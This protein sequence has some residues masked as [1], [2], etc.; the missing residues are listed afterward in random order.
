M[1]A[2]TL[3]RK[4]TAKS[5]KRLY[6][7]FHRAGAVIFGV[8][9]IVAATNI[10]ICAEETPTLDPQRPNVF[11]MPAY[12]ARQTR[13]T[14][15]VLLLV[16]KKQYAEAEK[17]LRSLIRQYPH[18]PT[19][20]Y[21]LGAVLARQNKTEEAF[22][23]LATAIDRGFANKKVMK[24][25]ADLDSLRHLPRFQK[26]IKKQE[27]VSARKRQQASAQFEL[28]VVQAARARVTA[29]NTLWVPRNNILVSAF[30]FSPKPESNHVYGGD[31]PVARRLNLW[32]G[33][34][35]AAG[36]HGD[37]YDNRDG[38]HSSI[39][40]AQLPQLAHIEYSG[41]ARQA[42]THYGF[43]SHFL[44]S[45]ITFGNSS[46]ALTGG[47]FWRSQA[48][49]ALTTPLLTQRLY[50]QFIND[51]IYVF[52]EH[53]DHDPERGDLLPANTPYMIIS[54]GS[55]GSDKP[56]LHAISAILAAFKPEVKAFLRSKHLVMPTLQMVFRKG[57]KHIV[58]QDD[59]L[60]ARAHPSVFEADTID[61]VKMIK[62]ANALR[63]ETLPPRMQ[64]FVVE[65]SRAVLGKDY[66]APPDLRETLFN[67]S[68]AIARVVRSTKGN[69]RMV[70]SAAGTADPNGRSLKFHWRVLR[71]DANRIKITPRNEEG[72]VAELVIPWHERR[73]V[74]FKPKLTT[75]RVDIAVFADNG[76][77][78]SAPAFVSLLYPADQERSYDD[79]GRI[80]QVDYAALNRRER[81]VDPL[82]FPGR[83]WTDSYQYSDRGE[84]LGWDRTRGKTKERFTRHG[85]RVIETDAAG[86][87]RRA[88]L[89]RYEIKIP[90]RGRPKVAQIPTGKF[91][92]YH[93]TGRNDLL[94]EPKPDL[95][96]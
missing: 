72:S 16:R 13:L 7:H 94:G 84:L 37:L 11:Q 20:H 73:P 53:L 65:E 90:K 24:R 89:V 87:P 79:Q 38:G 1:Y 54:Q 6:G 67:T 36:N 57:L 41:E 27:A 70:I 56:F 22:G 28:G 33:R 46:T 21:N 69:R 55:S 32:F 18:W 35:E 52:P 80:K 75:D 25:D 44:F 30:K 39:T 93:Y 62:L 66:F 82:L 26:L 86:R 47:T 2:P 31:G 8:A 58:T 51:Q 88:E 96:R 78:V 95:D 83:D 5:L 60:S 15:P 71:G 29:A 59:Y 64:L 76:E 48:R 23:A 50:Q 81:Y 77:N 42:K 85:A 4:H 3:T 9:V 74:P 40:R 19:H 12:A 63:V 34:D 45:A 17:E 14:L 68:G 10:G 92:T 43:N 91:V 49:L 61:L